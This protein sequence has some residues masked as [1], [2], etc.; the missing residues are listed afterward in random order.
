MLEPITEADGLDDVVHGMTRER[1]EVNDPAN[2]TE[3]SSW[4]YPGASTHNTWT[5]ADQTVLVTSDEKMLAVAADA[6]FNSLSRFN[7]AFKEL[8]GLTPRQ[9]RKTHQ[10]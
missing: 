3:I 7:A 2:I 10:P 6:G 5:S 1:G 8:C 4:T 9:F